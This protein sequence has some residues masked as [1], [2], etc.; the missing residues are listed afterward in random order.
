MNQQISDAIYL[1]LPTFL[2]IFLFLCCAALVAQAQQVFCQTYRTLPRNIPFASVNSNH[3]ADFVR[4]SYFIL[5]G[6]QMREEVK[7]WAAF[8]AE[9]V[10]AAALVLAS[11]LTLWALFSPA[12]AAGTERMVVPLGR[13]V[14]I[15]LFS[16]GVI[17][18]GMSDINTETGTIN[19]AKSCGLQEGDIITHINSEEVDSIEEVRDVLQELEGKPMSIR[20]VRG[21]KQVQMTAQAA[22]CA[23]D[24]N[25]KL[26][27]WIRDSMAGIGTMT[28]YDPTSG[29]FGALGHGVNDSDTAQLM[30]L[31]AGSILYAEV[32]KVQKGESG[33]PGLLQGVFKAERDL[34]TLFSNS[35]CGIFGF[36]DDLDMTEGL[37]AIPVAS[38]SEVVAGPAT[39]LSN[40]AG[41]EVREY[42]IEITR[43]FS[44][45]PED[46]RN[47]MIHVTDPEL[48]EVTGGIVQGMSGS[49]VIQ[50]GKLVGAVTHVL[51]NDP[52]RG[53]GIFAD[54]MLAAAE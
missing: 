52:T 16:D 40:I 6:D 51:V 35:Q 45:T 13:A 44:A 49:P 37:A 12:A 41:K 47:F 19:P 32:L 4:V 34:G 50:N 31:E 18:V 1:K 25:Y 27:A 38:G 15:K 54:N 43:I 29:K 20:A 17:V 42:S 28:F 46:P 11:L 5:R 30:P 26:G 9:P 3:S 22:L 8:F 7:P 39:I 48:L 2:V 14:G 10:R 23:A 33:S 36:L 21:D 53:Y 24:G